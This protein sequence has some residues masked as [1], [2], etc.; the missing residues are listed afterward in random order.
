MKFV[1]FYMGVRGMDKR[2]GKMMQFAREETGRSRN[3]MADSLDVT[4]K[5]IWSWENGYSYPNAKQLFDWFKVLGSDIQ[6]Y[7]NCYFT[8]DG[9]HEVSNDK[10]ITKELHKMIDSYKPRRRELL[11]Y[12]LCGKHGADMDALMNLEVAYLQTTWKDRIVQSAMI[13]S[14]YRMNKERRQQKVEPNT[15]LISES[16]KSC[17]ESYINDRAGYSINTILY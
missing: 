5:T 6:I 13:L 11:H 9:K 10:E 7:M 17:A 16:I 3:F 12:I 4:T 8:T 1:N 15:D 14:N 2:Y